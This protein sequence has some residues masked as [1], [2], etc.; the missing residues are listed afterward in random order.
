M[1]KRY[2]CK[3]CDAL[4]DKT[5]TCDKACSLYTAT[6]PCTKGHSKHCDTCNRSFL[7]EKCFQNPLNLK[8]KR[9]LV[10]QWRQVCRNCNFL[11]T[12]DSKHECFKKFCTYCN[13]KQPSSHLCY[14]APPKP[15]KL[16]DR[17]MYVL[18]DTECT[19]DLERHEGSFE[20]VPNLICAQQVCSKC[21]TIKD[22]NVDCEQCGK[23]VHV[24]WQDS[25]GKFID[26]LRQS[27]P[28]ADKIFVISHN[29]RGYD[30][31]FLLRSFLELRWVPKLIM[32]GT[33]FLVCVWNIYIFWIHSM[34]CLC[35]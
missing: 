23:R 16:S 17:F 13:K 22:N 1:G 30:A 3:A 11:I 12:T 27:R 19:Q 4:Y 28:F 20:Y 24:F 6:Q 25:V 15:S 7:S 34:A 31:Q 33:K 5:H 18:F 9:K 26:Y 10:C 35:V 32:D 8:V 21:E 29:S 2:I 14:M